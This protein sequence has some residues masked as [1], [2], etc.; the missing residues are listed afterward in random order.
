[1]AD[2]PTSPF[3][4]Q[5]AAALRGF[6]EQRNVQQADLAAHLGKSRGY[7]SE[8]LSGKRAAT[9]DMLDGVA[10]LA[11]IPVRD[12]YDVIS[13]RMEDDETIDEQAD[14]LA[15]NAR[16]RPEAV[17]ARKRSASKA[18]RAGKRA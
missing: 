14:R 10:E 8:H 6:M 3:S 12:L 17:A 2:K 13:R 4:R 15:A 1:M 16:R 5:F 9:T 11:G 7:I 18:G